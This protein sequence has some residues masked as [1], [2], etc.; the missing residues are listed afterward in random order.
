MIGERGRNGGLLRQFEKE[1]ER[2]HHHDTATDSA[3]CS[4]DAADN[5]DG[6][7]G[8]NGGGGH[9]S[10]G[11]SGEH[12]DEQTLQHELWIERGGDEFRVGREAGFE[13]GVQFF[14]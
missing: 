1:H 14:E 10:T 6:E 2:R 13:G 3:Q 5:A 4:D 12:A 11:L 7:T 8:E 9:E